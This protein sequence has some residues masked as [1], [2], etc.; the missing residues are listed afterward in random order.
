MGCFSKPKTEIKQSSLL[1]PAQKGWMSDI[2]D[3]LMPM[4]GQQGPSY[5]GQRV[6]G[7]SP[8]QGQPGGLRAPV[9][10]R[11]EHVVAAHQGHGGGRR[12]R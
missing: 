5:P 3:W 12:Q 8:L 1:T 6:A 7:A 11:T 4:I 2:G 9:G 10:D